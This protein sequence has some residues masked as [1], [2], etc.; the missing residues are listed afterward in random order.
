MRNLGITI[1][2][3]TFI[4]L[5]IKTASDPDN[6]AKY[7]KL[8]KHLII[9]TV[10]ISVSL[11]LVEIP[12]YYFGRTVEITDGQVT[13]MTFDK[14]EDKDCQDRET[15]NIDGKRY[16]VTD[17]GVTL[18]AIEKDGV[19][20]RATSTTSGI[21]TSFGKYKLEN[22]SILRLFS[23][24]QGT[25]KGYF[26]DI[27]YY[28]DSKGIIFPVTATYSEYLSIKGQGGSF[29]ARRRWWWCKIEKL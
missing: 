29:G 14:I 28:R 15:V 24:S 18:Y 20:M 22:C 26:A 27:K 13:G 8:S 2:S 6:K 25:F 10:L 17:E 1:A 21:D 3:I 11:T 12:K 5:M 4:V 19:F 9:A 23:E 16:V 7:L